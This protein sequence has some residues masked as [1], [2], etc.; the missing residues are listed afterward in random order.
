MNFSFSDNIRRLI[1]KR[2]NISFSKSGEDMQLKKLLGSKKTG[3]FVDIGCWHP[4]KSSNTYYFSL[5]NWKGICIDPN[6]ELK[7]LYA[8]YRNNDIFINCGVGVE[9]TD[10][11]QYYMLNES[12]MNTFDKLFLESRDLIQKVTA[13]KEIPIIKLSD[14]L[15]RNLSENEIIDFF[16]IDVEGYDLDVLKSNDW[17]K[18]RPK[19]VLV[20]TN[21]CIR[22]DLKSEISTYLE[23][24]NYEL[25]GKSIMNAKIDTGNLFFIDKVY[26]YEDR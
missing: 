15:E 21:L 6:P 12:S 18:F 11:L 2:Y 9:T 10:K 24:V 1:Y 5:R 26:K 17:K 7:D 4:V 22:D 16:D 25:I 13:I 8:N 20:E 19:I 3:V 23:S 14:I